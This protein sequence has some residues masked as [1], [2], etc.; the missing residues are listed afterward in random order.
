MRLAEHDEMVERFAT[1]RSDEPLNVAVLPRR[2][3]CGGVISDPIARTRRVR[4][5]PN[6][7]SRS[8]IR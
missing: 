5:G 3:W 7:P 1:D 6:A 8:R 4:A 2:A